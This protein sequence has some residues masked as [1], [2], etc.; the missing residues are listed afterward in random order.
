M[1]Y[2][3]SFLNYLL[4]LLM[5]MTRGGRGDQRG[6]YSDWVGSLL[7]VD[8]LHEEY[9]RRRSEGKISGNELPDIFDVMIV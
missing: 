6:I 3:S 7:R 2:M 1:L 4:R 9:F 8:P 5:M